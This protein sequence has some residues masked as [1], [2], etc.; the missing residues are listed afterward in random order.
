MGILNLN[1][2]LRKRT[3]VFHAEKISTF[4]GK[5]VAVDISIRLYA[6]WSTQYKS[7]LGS[8]DFILSPVNLEAV[9]SE[10]VKKL[11]ARITKLKSYKMIPVIVFDGTASEEKKANSHERLRENYERNAKRVQ[12]IKSKMDAVHGD[13]KYQYRVEYRKALMSDSPRHFNKKMVEDELRDKLSAGGYEV[14][15]AVG[16]ADELCAALAIEGKVDAVYSTDTDL[17]VRGCPVIIT[18]IS[19]NDDKVMVAEVCR[20]G[21]AAL[22]TLG[23]TRAE[24]VD[25]CILAGCDYNT[26]LKHIAVPTAY[27]KIKKHKTIEA[28]SAAENRD[29][30]VLNVA[31]CRELFTYRPSEL[32]IKN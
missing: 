20:F 28:F 22:S 2:F 19:L 3:D 30:T 8:I 24:F 6:T 15:N 25:M 9:H 11:Y 7:A 14:Y 4:A 18:D 12:D 21:D 5:K 1:P 32:L 31:R 13:D 26:G 27:K 10:V 29:I 17:I 16:E 23:I